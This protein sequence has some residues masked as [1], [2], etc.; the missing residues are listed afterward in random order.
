MN[1]LCSPQLNGTYL[2]IPADTPEGISSAEMDFIIANYNDPYIT[3]CWYM[4][5]KN[6]NSYGFANTIVSKDFTS[7]RLYLSAFADR[8]SFYKEVPTNVWK[9]AISTMTDEPNL[10]TATIATLAEDENGE[11]YLEVSDTFHN[12]IANQISNIRIFA[13]NDSMQVGYTISP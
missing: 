1:L 11:V 8:A 12:F 7:N 5:V 2:I 10:L 6:K 4:E 13:Y 9:V 3:N